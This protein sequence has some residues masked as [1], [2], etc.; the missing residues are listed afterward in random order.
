MD[1]ELLK[2]AFQV[3]YSL[4]HKHYIYKQWIVRKYP[5]AAKFIWERTGKRINERDYKIKIK[6]NY[7]ELSKIISQISGKLLKDLFGR[8]IISKSN[9][10]PSEFYYYNNKK[11]F[12]F[13][14]TYFKESLEHINDSNLR[15]DLLGLF[16]SNDHNGKHLAL[17]LL[18]AIKMFKITN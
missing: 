3:P 1:L 15:S 12:K 13:T 4:R 14:N 8:K 6:G 11:L 7:Y 10:N 18:S 5:L 9:M 16:N 2:F 17:T